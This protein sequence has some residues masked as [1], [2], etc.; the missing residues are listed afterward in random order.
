MY[1]TTKK[2][3]MSLNKINGEISGAIVFLIALAQVMNYIMRSLG[4]PLLWV[5]EITTYGMIVIV[6]LGFAICQQ[7]KNHVRVEM[8]ILYL[9]KYWYWIA[10]I[11]ALLMIVVF[12]SIMFYASAIEAWYTLEF[13]HTTS[14]IIPVPIYPARIL[15]SFGLFLYPAVIILVRK[16]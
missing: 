13:R 8:L 3:M 2:I 1:D 9:P 14:G 12:G 5:T 15:L 16:N 4:M 10:N 7:N 11:F 6:Y